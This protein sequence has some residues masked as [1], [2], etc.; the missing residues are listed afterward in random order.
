M[1]FQR[2]LL[3]HDVSYPTNSK[4]EFLD[5]CVPHFGLTCTDMQGATTEHRSRCR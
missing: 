3:D 5:L 4:V 1:F 2:D